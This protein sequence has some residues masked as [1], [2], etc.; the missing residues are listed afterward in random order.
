MLAILLQSL[1]AWEPFVYREG[2][3]SLPSFMLDYLPGGRFMP[4]FF[5]NFAPD[6]TMLIEENNGFALLDHPRVYFEGDSPH[7]FNWYMAGLP[8]GSALYD[9]QAAFSVPALAVE[10]FRLKGSSPL[11]QGS[12]LD[13]TLRSG[14]ERINVFSV[15][16]AFSRLGG[17]TALGK[18]AIINHPTNR[19]Q[20]LYD[21][22]RRIA[23]NVQLDYLHQGALARG[24][25]LF[26]LS[27]LQ[28]DRNFNDFNQHN[29]MF[30][31]QGER[32]SLLARHASSRTG[33]YRSFSLVYEHQNR[34]RLNA[35]LGRLPQETLARNANT[36]LAALEMSFG[37]TSANLSLL[38]ERENLS[39]GQPGWDKNL[40]DNDGE[41]FLPFHRQGRFAADTLRLLLEHPLI[42]ESAEHPFKLSLFADWAA[43]F[44]SGRET[45]APAHALNIGSVPYRVLLQHE[46]APYRHS[47]WRMVSGGLAV[48]RPASFLSLQGKILLDLAANRYQDKTND[49]LFLSPGFDLGFTL[50]TGRGS[51]LSFA[52][53]NMPYQMGAES[54]FF[55]EQGRPGGEMRSWN[56]LNLDGFFQPG[57]EGALLGFHGG[58]FH[59]LA[60]DFR[61]T[62]RRRFLLDYSMPVG[63]NYRLQLKG[64]HKTML[65]Q[66]WVH[67]GSEYGFFENIGDYDFFFYDR[68]YLDFQLGNQ[69]FTKNPFYAQL[70]IHF[71]GARENR[72]FFSFSW[73][74]HIGMGPTAFGNGAGAND[75]GF[76]CESM[77]DPNSRINA[78][79]RLDGDRAFIGR[80]IYGRY[81]A[82]NFFLALNF[83]YRDGNPFAFF[84]T[85]HR[86][87]QHIIYY[88][89]IKAENER[90]VKGGPREDCLWDFSLQ[91]NYTFRLF[92]GEARAF[93]GF[94]NLLDFASEL[95]EYAFS[96]GERLAM[97]LQMPRS[98]RIGLQ[99]VF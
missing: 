44:V 8:M 42:G 89:T 85:L 59:R 9:G 4:S 92:G 10:S 43:V 57:E 7:H 15:S 24:E 86:H 16:S 53:E 48:F 31:E 83:K 5:E 95:S 70:L 72:W 19:N 26:A 39:P 46:A 84:E 76:I 51:S 73:L 74:S 65:N 99:L 64:I 98:M 82:R 25:V 56:D 61:R 29:T 87:G 28:L 30:A 34:D 50:H 60:D 27:Y 75:L 47:R 79:G 67:H 35:E 71:S 62:G 45:S 1:S 81:L 54:A 55:L 37:R 96:G 69:D 6:T 22:R 63:R 93:L 49:F 58:P 78:Y 80:L 20:M 17:M 14:S 68:P 32:L 11:Y 94:F 21:T 18:I 36:M 88:Q 97:E 23:K 2:V 90:G 33:P 3:I 91:F 41:G 40:L 12:G 66:A 38:V 77:A 52:F 13:T